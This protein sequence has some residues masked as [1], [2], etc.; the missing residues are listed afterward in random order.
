MMTQSEPWRG[1]KPA[2]GAC[3][4]RAPRSFGVRHREG[5]RWA[6]RAQSRERDD[7]VGR[8]HLLGRDRLG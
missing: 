7:L 5:V 4:A 8:A 3:S 2:S 1:A 6:R